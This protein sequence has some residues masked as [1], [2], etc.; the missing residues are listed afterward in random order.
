[1]DEEN[2]S[3]TQNDRN[4]RAVEEGTSGGNEGDDVTRFVGDE[5]DWESEEGCHLKCCYLFFYSISRY[6]KYQVS[7][8]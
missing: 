7:I 2:S 3:I 4:N 6:E 5:F 1:M 8:D